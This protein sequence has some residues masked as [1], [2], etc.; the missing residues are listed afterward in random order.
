MRQ[1][2]VYDLQYILL[3]GQRLAKKCDKNVVLP[4]KASFIR[5][6]ALVLPPEAE[7]NCRFLSE[8]CFNR[9]RTLERGQFW[10]TY[11]QTVGKRL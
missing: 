7:I 8:S 4:T 9:D 2:F 6:S 3:M 1:Q 5:V 11:R 10:F